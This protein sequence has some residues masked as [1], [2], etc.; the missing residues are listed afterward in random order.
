MKKILVKIGGSVTTKKTATGFP[1]EIEQIKRV[2]GNYINFSSIKRIAREELWR[3]SAWL[4]E[5]GSIPAFF[6]GAGIFGHSLV[7]S[8]VDG[9][10][11]H[12]CGVTYANLL[13]HH[14]NEAI[15]GKSK[16][17]FDY[18]EDLSPRRILKYDGDKIDRQSLMN[19]VD[20]LK[21]FEDDD[22]PYPIITGDMA[23]YQKGL[24]P[25][26]ADKIIS[27]LSEVVDT[28]RIIMGISAKGVYDTNPQ[29]SNSNLIRKISVDEDLSELI[30]SYSNDATGGI[31][32]KVIA[33]QKAAKR[34]IPGYIVDA[35]KPMAL[36]HA[37]IGDDN[38]FEG[39]LIVP[40]K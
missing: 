14:L 32:G 17:P 35:N 30:K 9:E 23:S 27:E 37:I 19:F 5:K 31:L 40:K 16:N 3:A 28:E 26:S 10:I 6:F 12:D 4:D 22:K 36:F 34:G 25:L 1:L 8:G 33:L 20:K 11:V 13:E 39:T 15:G 2:A 29:Y 7:I 18:V 21:E 24:R 38:N